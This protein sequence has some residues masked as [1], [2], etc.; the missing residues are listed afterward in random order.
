MNTRLIYVLA[1]AFSLSAGAVWGGECGGCGPGCQCIVPP[2]PSCPDCRD[3]CSRLR[4]GTL[5]GTAH[6]ANLIE[7]LHH[8]AAHERLKAVRKLGC[9]LH[10]DFCCTPEVLH[11]LVHAL[12]CDTCWEVRRHAA[13]AIARQDA[14]VPQGIVALHLAGRL[15]PH[16]MVRDAAR[17]ALDVLLVCRRDCY[18]ELLVDADQLA[19]QLREQYKPTTGNCIQLLDDFLEQC[20]SRPSTLPIPTKP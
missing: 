7:R 13:W 11:A 4:L 20:D 2:S 5:C 16:F 10:A 12:M 1:A 19:K 3:P 9:R 15:D 6:T 8:D 14:R 18:K 17:D